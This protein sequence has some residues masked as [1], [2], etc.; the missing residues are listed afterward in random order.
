MEELKEFK[1]ELEEIL[2]RVNVKLEEDDKKYWT[3]SGSG[4]ITSLS[5]YSDDFDRFK[6][7]IGNYFKTRE[8]AEEYL[9]DLK[10]KTEIKNIA[11][12]LNKGK[13]ID[14][15]DYDIDKYYLYYSYQYKSLVC[16]SVSGSKEEGTTY[17]LD[18]NFMD[19]CVERIGKERLEKYLKRN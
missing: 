1:K 6:K 19:V 9:E 10:V 3:V 18:R 17:C 5:D 14:W 7:E 15:N 11:K 2:E 12:E 4:E 8:E 16:T 13:E